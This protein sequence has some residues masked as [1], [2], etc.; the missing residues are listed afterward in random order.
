MEQLRKNK[1]G[2][3]I[4]NKIRIKEEVREQISNES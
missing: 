2:E 4:E 3:Q 1:R